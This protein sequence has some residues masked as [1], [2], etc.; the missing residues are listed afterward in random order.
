MVETEFG[1]HIML[2][3]TEGTRQV[4]KRR[5]LIKKAMAGIK[6]KITRGVDVP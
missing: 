2:L 6:A 3:R 1:F 5:S 4:L